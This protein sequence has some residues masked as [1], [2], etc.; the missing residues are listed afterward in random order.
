MLPDPSTTE[1]VAKHLAE[2][3]PEVRRVGLFGDARGFAASVAGGGAPPQICCDGPRGSQVW[4]DCGSQVWF[5]RCDVHCTR[6]FRELV[7]S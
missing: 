1:G 3:Y 6:S 5:S 2:A 4:L 7:R